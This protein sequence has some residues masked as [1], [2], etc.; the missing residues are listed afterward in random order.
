M[1][2]FVDLPQFVLTQNR[3]DF[4]PLQQNITR[5]PLG[6]DLIGHRQPNLSPSFEVPFA[7]GIRLPPA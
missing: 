2:G 5:L 6:A 7:K 1:G 4:V 3:Y